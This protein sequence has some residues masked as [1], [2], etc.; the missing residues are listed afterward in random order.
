MTG[1]ELKAI[2]K[3]AKHKTGSVGL[4]TT[5]LGAALGYEGSAN[6]RSVTIR[7]YENGDRRIPPWIARLMLM[8]A[9]HGIPK[10]WY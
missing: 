3:S 8:F 4:S 10:D 6:T 7:K 2:R 9:R 5:E 1:E